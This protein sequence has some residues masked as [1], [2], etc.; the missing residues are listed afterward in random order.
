MIGEV[1]FDHGG[2]RLTL[3]LGTAAQC[4]LEQMHD[5]GFFAIVEKALP[6]VTPAMLEDPAAMVEAARGVRVH[7]LRDI[8][9]AAL[10]KHH[11]GTTIGEVDDLIDQIGA[12]QF[13]A[14]IGRT[15]SAG[16]GKPIEADGEG[17]GGAAPGKPP[18]PRA[19]RARKRT[20]KG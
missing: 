12:Q 20:G 7:M 9:W 1:T 5:V 14:L 2:R 11:P 4:R 15:I 10:Q 18:K 6:N 19:T 13:G 8:A 16:Q 17:A 3:F